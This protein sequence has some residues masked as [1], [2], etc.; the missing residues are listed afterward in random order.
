MDLDTVLQGLAIT[1]AG[2]ALVF[3]ALGLL[4]VAMELMRRFLRPRSTPEK[5]PVGPA[6]DGPERARVAAMTAAIVLAQS[7]AKHHPNDAWRVPSGSQ[8]ANPWQASHRS[9]TL[10][11]RPGESPERRTRP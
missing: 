7:R 5:A 10:A 11:R 4:V 9:Q 1:I 2:M 8:G 6:A 3:L